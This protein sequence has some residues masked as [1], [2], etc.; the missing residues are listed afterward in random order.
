MKVGYYQFHPVFG[1]VRHNLD[2]VISKLSGINADLIVLPEL[3][4]TGYYFRDRGEVGK[5][6]EEPARSETVGAL[7][8]LCRNKK[9][10]LVT[11]FAEKARDR[12]FL[13][14]STASCISSTRS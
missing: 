6:A 13:S 12:Y 14:M 7:A 9:M 10:Y 2:K 5:L 3:A 8:A 4:F 11:G 1:K